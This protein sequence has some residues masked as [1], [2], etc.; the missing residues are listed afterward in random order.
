MSYDVVVLLSTYNGAKYI[1][2]QLDSLIN[3]REVKIKLI[4]RD[5]GSSDSTLSIL[6]DYKDKMDIYVYSGENLGAAFSFLDLIMKA[7]EAKYYAF[8]DQDDIWLPTKVNRAIRMISNIDESNKPVLYCSDYQLIDSDGNYI[9]N[10][11]HVS[12]INFTDAI[13]NSCCTGCTTVFNSELHNLLKMYKPKS[14]V[15]HDDWAHKVCLACGGRVIFDPAKTLLYRQHANNVE[16][17][18]RSIIDRLIQLSKNI[19]FDKPCLRRQELIELVNGYSSLMNQADIEYCKEIIN[20]R[21]SVGSKLKI[22]LSP[23]FQSSI[24]AFNLG[25]KLAILFGYY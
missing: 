23:K 12:S 1:A 21:T 11:G 22:L 10:R 14:I 6:A 7:P 24:S 4:V 2:E 19:F 17:G 25:F 3:Q 5:D 20:Y 16:G 18:N 15:M 9:R 8:C 13:I